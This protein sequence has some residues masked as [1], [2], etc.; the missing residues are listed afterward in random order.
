MDS[1][2]QT[3]SQEWRLLRKAMRASIVNAAD[4]AAHRD[5]RAFERI[6]LPVET[7]D[8]LGWLRLQNAPVQTYWSARDGRFEMAGAGV[9]EE[10][11][12][13]SPD[14]M[15]RV[16]ADVTRALET[17]DQG[18]RYYGGLRFYGTHPTDTMW[19]SFPAC[20]FILPRFE[21]VC[22]AG[23]TRLVCNLRP[24]GGEEEMRSALAQLEELQFDVAPPEK[25]FPLPSRRDDCP[26]RPQ[27]A[28]VVDDALAALREGS[29]DKIVLARRS[30]LELAAP[31]AAALLHRLKAVTPECFHFAFQVSPSEAFVGASPERLYRRQG[32]AIDTEAVAGTRPRLEDAHADAQLGAGLLAS[33]KDRREHGFV[34][35]AI[36]AALDP[37]CRSLSVDS[38]MSLL[39]L[40]RG[41]HL[42]TGFRGELRDGP[43]DADLLRLLHPTP[44]V[45]GCPTEAAL[46]R[47][48]QWEGFDRGWYAAPV[49]WLGR[50]SAEFAVGIR[51][52]LVQGNSLA[53]FAGA[54][55]VTGSTAQGE[56]D[57]VEHKVGDFIRILT[58]D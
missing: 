49:G 8:V 51:S 37:V 46:L 53:L 30:R 26:D 13:G 3:E 54:G 47:I 25:P 50:D 18:L 28:R 24:R 27:W 36:R 45:G 5:P 35:D 40:A 56:W 22:E 4:S 9:A 10:L 48:K 12:A 1:H 44:A 20:R 43:S 14:A 15:G 19:S 2:R 6:A 17:G 41:Q 39:K 55:I 31:L 21:L 32:R 52:A 16:L 57:E 34:R 38:E 58:G 23:R 33:D 29:L 7:T 42:F 11:A